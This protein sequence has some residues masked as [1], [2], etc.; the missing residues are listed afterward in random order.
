METSDH[1]WEFMRCV[2]VIHLHQLTIP[3]DPM[4]VTMTYIQIFIGQLFPIF[5]IISVYSKAI[6]RITH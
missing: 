2:I 1:I 4:R 5:A 6:E 3:F